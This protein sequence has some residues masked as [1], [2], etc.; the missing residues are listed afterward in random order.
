MEKK[1]LTFSIILF[2][3]IGVLAGFS[4]YDISPNHSSK[5]DNVPLK[6]VS[7]VKKNLQVQN[8]TDGNP[9][10][11]AA[12][13]YS[14]DFNGANDTNALKARGYKVYYRGSTAQ[15]S[16]VWFQ[17]NPA[18]FP[19]FNGPTNGYVGGNYQVIADPPGLGNID[20]WL[21]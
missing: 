17:G 10:H 19:A 7:S 2:L 9:I 4:Y 13:I 6:S 11:N 18:V 21:V 1:V 15:G 12:I 14:D 3:I 8:T 16:A 20:S 5:M